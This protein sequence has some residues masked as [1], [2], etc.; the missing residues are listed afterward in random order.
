MHDEVKKGEWQTLEASN[1]SH[2][3]HH[4]WQQQVK[5]FLVVQTRQ[6]H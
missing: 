1:E 6:I 5:Q 3:I 2:L 4:K